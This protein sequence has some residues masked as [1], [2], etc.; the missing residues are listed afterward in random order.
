VSREPGLLRVGVAGR[1]ATLVGALTVA[2]AVAPMLVTAQAPAGKTVW[3]G[4]YTEAQAARGRSAYQ[5]HCAECHGASLEGGEAVA[6]KGDRFNLS[7]RESSVDKL[8]KQIST[9][10]PMSEDGSLAGSLARGVYVDIVALVLQNNGFP[11]GS[12]ELTPENAVGV[13]IY[14]KTGPGEL[15]HSASAQVV[16][17]LTK[18][19]PRAWKVTR[20][21]KPV[22]SGPLETPLTAAAALG[23]REFPLLFVL[24][25]LDKLENHRVLVTGR[26]EGEAG[27]KGLN[28]NTVSSQGAACQ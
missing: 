10:M 8:F 13:A 12:A 25:N 26:L 5:Q 1:V 28:V 6:L 19:G 4:V 15:P 23:D 17:C 20:G 2:G 16:G 7:W 14:A 3:D 27:A 9:N 18:T 11:A 24:T 22:R 21:S